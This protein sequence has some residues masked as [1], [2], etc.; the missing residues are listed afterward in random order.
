[1]KR[2]F[3]QFTEKLIE[4]LLLISGSLTSITALLIVIFLFKEGLGLFTTSP[5]ENKNV[6]VV[7]KLNPVEHLTAGQIK[8]IFDQEITNWK[9][10]GGKNDT[11][12]LFTINDLSN[13]FSEEEI[14]ENFEYLTEKLNSIVES[15]TNL[16][17]VY[18]DKYLVKVEGQVKKIG[19]HKWRE[20]LSLTDLLMSI[21]GLTDFG[22]SSNVEISRR[23]RDA[24]VRT[25]NHEQTKIILV[26]LLKG[27]D[28]ILQPYDIISGKNL[29]VYSNQRNV[30]V[31]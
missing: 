3:K 24:D 18:K 21:G 28:A 30:M 19:G 20:N 7:N 27:N 17:A 11:I 4:G 25:A 31:Q 13:Y 6:I 15:I 26:N 2:K 10:L 8:K 29:P 9:D 1:M 14:G 16:L 5:M 22:D 23:L 12:L